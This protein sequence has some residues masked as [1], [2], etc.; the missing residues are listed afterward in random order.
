MALFLSEWHLGYLRRL[1]ESSQMPRT[2][3]LCPKQKVSILLNGIATTTPIEKLRM[4]YLP[5]YIPN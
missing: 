1:G 2:K 3:A 4:I 5:C